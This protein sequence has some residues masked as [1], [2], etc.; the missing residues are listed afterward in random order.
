MLNKIAKLTITSTIWNTLERTYVA[1]SHSHVLELR[2]E[3]QSIK[4]DALIID[5]YVF[6]LKSI[7]DKLVSIGEPV[8]NRDQLISIFQGL[9]CKYN[10][11]VTSLN[12]IFDQPTIKEIHSFLLSF[13]LKLQRQNV[14]EQ[15]NVN[16]DQ[17]NLVAFNNKKPFKTNQQ[18]FQNF[19]IKSLT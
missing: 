13:G 9:G 10:P 16:M 8:L 4:K 18:N 12:A 5:K 2:T 7:A 19:S 11:F 1:T 6:K 3:I 14:V 17:A 15:M